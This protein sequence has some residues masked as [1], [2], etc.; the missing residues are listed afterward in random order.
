MTNDE[1]QKMRGFHFIIF[2][3]DVLKKDLWHKDEIVYATTPLKAAELYVSLHFQIQD[4]IH[5][6]QEINLGEYDVFIRGNDNFETKIR[7][8]S[9]RELDLEIPAYL[10]FQD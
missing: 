4:H 6:M 7:V 10:R 3:Q 8:K 5:S 9:C 1:E 2:T